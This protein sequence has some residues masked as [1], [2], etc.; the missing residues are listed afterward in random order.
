MPPALD[1]FRSATDRAIT[2][3]SHIGTA[4]RFISHP[5][6]ARATED[7]RLEAAALR[8]YANTR[9]SGEVTRPRIAVLSV[10]AEPSWLSDARERLRPL[11]FVRYDEVPKLLHDLGRERFDATVLDGALRGAD[12]PCTTI[13][14]RHRALP[15][16]CWG[17]AE[18]GSF[19]E[20]TAPLVSVRSTDELVKFLTRE[21]TTQAR[22]QLAGVSLASIVQV[23]QL[24]RRSC[25]LRAR[26]GSLSGKL[27]IHLGALVHATLLSMPPRESALEMLSWTDAEVDFDRLPQNTPVTIEEPLDFLVIEAARVRDEVGPPRRSLWPGARPSAAPRTTSSA[28][29]MSEELRQ[30]LDRLAR[31]VIAER[32]C[33]LCAMIDL[34]FRTVVAMY[35]KGLNVANPV[36]ALFDTLFSA[37]GLLTD[38][39]VKGRS[40]DIVITTGTSHVL[41]RPLATKPPVAAC[42]IFQRD[43]VTLGF[44]R[45]SFDQLVRAFDTERSS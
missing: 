40:E 18:T 39:G 11:D 19:A 10:V 44:C 15:I 12:S 23:L 26:V 3:R 8:C 20:R 1:S 38:I 22:G 9:R 41:L 21:V 24:E 36:D 32:G 43:V 4:R 6:L 16:A 17:A 45:S 27:F 35:S 13:A 28:V 7:A 2:T 33:A 37:S 34:E 5:M 31:E 42:A 25:R 30:S 29:A 14:T